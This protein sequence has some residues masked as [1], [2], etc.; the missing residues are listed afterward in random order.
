MLASPNM[1]KKPYTYS[2]RGRK[3]T[4]G[5]MSDLY[6]AMFYAWNLY[7]AKTFNKKLN[8]MYLTDV[9]MIILEAHFP[10]RFHEVVDPKCKPH[11]TEV[12]PEPSKPEKLLNHSMEG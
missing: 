9:F 8:N 2:F 12:F 4:P 6:S 1:E 7:K 10:Y 5:Y 3:R 11:Y